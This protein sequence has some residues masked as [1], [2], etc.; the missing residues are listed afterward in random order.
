[1]CLATF[2]AL[3]F[4]AGSIGSREALGSWLYKV[5]G[6]AARQAQTR[7]RGRAAGEQP[8]LDRPVSDPTPAFVWQELRPIL[9][10]E[11]QRLPD[12]YRVPFLLS[13]LEGRSNAEVARELGC[14][15][16]TVAS[17]LARARE[18]LRARLARRGVTLSAGAL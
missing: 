10:E 18:K 16:G 15:K 8:F 9:D 3:V 2:L 12:K 17:R 14:P 5:P 6:S 4:K 7:S 11:V 1:F 13:Y